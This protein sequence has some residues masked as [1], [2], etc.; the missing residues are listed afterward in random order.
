MSSSTIVEHEATSSNNQD[1]VLQDLEPLRP[2]PDPWKGLRVVGESAVARI[3]GLDA[4]R[5]VPA[6][7]ILAICFSVYQ[8]ADWI[9]YASIVAVAL[10]AM[11]AQKGSGNRASAPIESTKDPPQPGGLQVRA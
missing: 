5:L 4:D 6:G 9:P 10:G 7:A 2:E 1:P 8:Q 11:L 3:L